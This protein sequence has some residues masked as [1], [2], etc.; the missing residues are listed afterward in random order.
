M[1]KKYMQK[2][3]KTSWIYIIFAYIC[4]YSAREAQSKL[5]SDKGCQTPRKG[6]LTPSR[7]HQRSDLTPLAAQKGSPGHFLSPPPNDSKATQSDCLAPLP[8]YQAPQATDHQATQNKGHD[9]QST[10]AQTTTDDVRDVSGTVGDSSSSKD[11]KKRS[12]RRKK[13]KQVNDVL[14]KN[15]VQSVE[16]DCPACAS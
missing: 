4:T 3:D 12:R 11:A 2:M 1:S 6:P 10:A 7:D 13:P 8:D 5:T 16:T 9:H 15:M 14:K